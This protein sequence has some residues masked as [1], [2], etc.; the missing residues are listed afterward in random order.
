[1][2]RLG[3]V[4]V[5]SHLEPH[6]LVEH[7]VSSGQHQNGHIRSRADITEQRQAVLAARKDEIEKNRGKGLPFDR[8]PHRSAVADGSH[9]IPLAFELTDKH[10]PY[11][12]IVV[13]DQKMFRLLIR[14]CH[15][16]GPQAYLRSS[17][18]AESVTNCQIPKN[19]RNGNVQD[20]FLHNSPR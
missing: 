20:V 9:L 14:K 15:P 4:V 19:G 17:A 1:V 2:E 16:D 8:R 3:D 18:K 11:A 13:D 6:D 7:I 12:R 5:G 10:L